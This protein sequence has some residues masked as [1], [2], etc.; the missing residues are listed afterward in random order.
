M[1]LPKPQ[2]KERNTGGRQS[3]ETL[4]GGSLEAGGGSTTFQWWRRGR[5]HGCRRYFIV[6][7]LNGIS[8]DLIIWLRE[9]MILLQVLQHLYCSISRKY[10]RYIVSFVHKLNQVGNNHFGTFRDTVHKITGHIKIKID[11]CGWFLYFSIIQHTEIYQYAC[12]LCNEGEKWKTIKNVGKNMHTIYTC[13]S[14]L[15]K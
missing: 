15:Y 9:I 7:T 4:S 10:I 3:P 13:K 8:T 11:S 6:L 12:I 14:W 2:S 5:G 1:P